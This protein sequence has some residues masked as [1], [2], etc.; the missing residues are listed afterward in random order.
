MGF[1]PHDDFLLVMS[2]QKFINNYS[3]GYFLPAVLYRKGMGTATMI[4][5]V[6]S[7]FT[8]HLF[9][10]PEGITSIDFL[11][12][13]GDSGDLEP[14]GAIVNGKPFSVD[15]NYYNF[16]EKHSRR[17]DRVQLTSDGQRIYLD[18]DLFYVEDILRQ[19]QGSG[20]DYCDT[21]ETGSSALMHTR[22]RVLAMYPL[23][24]ESQENTEYGCI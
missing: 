7:R 5:P 22:E 2:E 21:D 3:P 9:G 14:A 12:N 20:T 16:F 6:V 24:P 18:E 8:R 13:F 15:A 19:C 1:S 10:N 23:A 11:S 4:T 17:F